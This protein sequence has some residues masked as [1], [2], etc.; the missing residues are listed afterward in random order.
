MGN[1]VTKGERRVGGNLKRCKKKKKGGGGEN[2]IF[3]ERL[4]GG[5][6]RLLHRGRDEMR[7]EERISRR[8][9]WVSRGGEGTD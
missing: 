7:E 6:L 2:A 4:K 5:S 9:R 3:D 8:I 1:D